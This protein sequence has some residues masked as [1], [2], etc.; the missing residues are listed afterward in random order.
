MGNAEHLTVVDRASAAL[1]PCCN[2]V[3]IH[4]V[5]LIN[6]ALVR[7]AHRAERAVGFALRFGI[8]RL[9]LVDRPLRGIIEHPHIQKLRVVKTAENVF[10][11][12]ATVLDVAAS[13][14]QTVVKQ[15]VRQEQLWTRNDAATRVIELE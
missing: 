8:A 4:F 2:V 1:A 11:D 5:E 12:A 13:P 15:N 7:A 9:F 3:G 10:E 6:P 14:T